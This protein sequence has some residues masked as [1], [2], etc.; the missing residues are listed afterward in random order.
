MT[1]ETRSTHAM[2]G[3]TQGFYSHA[4]TE[5]ATAMRFAVFVP[6]QAAV[7]TPDPAVQ[8]RLVQA[9][10]SVSFDYALTNSFGFGG[11]NASLVLRRFS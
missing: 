6:P 1:I 8:F 9:P 3:G 7:R 11:C 10:E 2:F 4:S 5:T